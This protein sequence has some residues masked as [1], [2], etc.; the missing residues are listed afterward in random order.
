MESVCFT[1]ACPDMT[2]EELTEMAEEK[3]EVKTSV[4]KDLDFLV[5]ADP[6][7]GSTKLE[8]AKKNGTKVISYEEFLEMLDEDD[9]ENYDD[10]EGLYTHAQAK[11]IMARLREAYGLEGARIKTTIAK[12]SLPM[13]ASKFGGYP[14]WEKGAEYPHYDSED[15]D[16][17]KPFVLL[18]QINFAEVPPLPDYP[19]KGLLQIFTSS[20]DLY[21][22]DYEDATKQ[23]LW[24][25]VWHDDFSE[26][27]AM[28]KRELRAMGV[29]SIVEALEEDDDALFPIEKEYALSFE[30]I[31]TIAKPCLNVF[32][33]YVRKAAKDLGLPVYE[34]S[35]LEM[36]GENDYNNFF[37]SKIAQH[38]IG[39][40]PFFCQ[41]D[42]SR[43]G[44][45]LLFQMDSEMKK[46]ICWGD[47]GVGNFFLSREDLKNLNFT[48]VLYNYDCD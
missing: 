26:E 10:E 9:D 48:N 7:S 24:R 35:A 23:E 45:L 5:C 6:N 8:K 18:A 40:F 36:F 1:G 4:T 17:A 22:M 27:K 20:D 13:T 28:S 41:G 30:K 47:L 44:D 11:Q 19:T 3:F 39:G 15:E 12:K 29:K 21:G 38:Q 46:G 33:E 2:R 31:V 25:I 14:Y 43:E 42:Q 32:E 16:E 34:E 37:E